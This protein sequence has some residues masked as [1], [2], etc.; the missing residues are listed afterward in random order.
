MSE[1]HYLWTILRHL[2]IILTFSILF[3]SFLH[4]SNYFPIRISAIYTPLP[5]LIFG[6]RKMF[7]STARVLR[8]SMSQSDSRILRPLPFYPNASSLSRSRYQST[9]AAVYVLFQH[10]W[11]RP[12]IL[13]NVTQHTIPNIL[14]FLSD[15]QN[16]HNIPLNTKP[17][18]YRNHV[19]PLVNSRHSKMDESYVSIDITTSMLKYNFLMTIETIRFIGMTGG[20]IFHQMMIRHNVKQIC[21]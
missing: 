8:R 2:S 17:E 7:P 4:I 16:T 1:S 20:E 3:N 19:H 18:K 12:E 15:T 6:N 5:T 9:A 10:Q 11:P 21:M 14:T 13:D